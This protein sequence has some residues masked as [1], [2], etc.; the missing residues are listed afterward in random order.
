[1]LDVS[2]NRRNRW[3]HCIQPPSKPCQWVNKHNPRA[4]TTTLTKWNVAIINVIHSTC[5]FPALST[6]NVSHEKGPIMLVHTPAGCTFSYR[7]ASSRQMDERVT[8]QCVTCTNKTH[9][10][11]PETSWKQLTC[12]DERQRSR[13]CVFQ[14]QRNRRSPA[15]SPA[16]GS[17]CRDTGGRD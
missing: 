5:A 12:P 15:G 8:A 16:P 2:R 13:R 14:S 4:P 10:A 11:P 17:A 9:T 7:L 6:Q 1:M 3:L